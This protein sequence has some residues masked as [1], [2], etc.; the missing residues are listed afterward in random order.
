MLPLSPSTTPWPPRPPS[1]VRWRSASLPT[2][3]PSSTVPSS[4]SPSPP[5]PR[6]LL[7]SPSPGQ[8]QR[9]TWF[10]KPQPLATAYPFPSPRSTSATSSLPL[11]TTSPPQLTLSWL[12]FL[13][14]CP[15]PCSPAL[16]ASWPRCAPTL[17]LFTQT[18]WEDSKAQS[19][20]WRCCQPSLTSVSQTRTPVPLEIDRLP[21]TTTSPSTLQPP[22]L[23]AF[24]GLLASHVPGLPGPL[25]DACLCLPVFITAAP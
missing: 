2:A 15:S 10:L 22:T 19:S 4:V 5:L 24:P 1:P 25:V 14:G 9:I 12:F 13:P 7:Q 21:F 16:P 20:L 6:F 23:P 3:G 17:Q 18:S 11:A 8:R